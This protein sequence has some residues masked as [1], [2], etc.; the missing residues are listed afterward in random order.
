[1]TDG[2]KVIT[3]PH[4]TLESGGAKQD[5]NHNFTLKAIQAFA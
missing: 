3:I 5:L 1:M 4:M 2:P